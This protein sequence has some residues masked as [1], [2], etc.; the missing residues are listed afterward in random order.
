[1]SVYS[2]A[3]AKT[4]NC[5]VTPIGVYELS[6]ATDAAA[7]GLSLTLFHNSFQAHFSN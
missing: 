4:L 7:A 2:N 6:I 3:S 5:D 1:M